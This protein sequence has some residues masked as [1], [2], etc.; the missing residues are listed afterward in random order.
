VQ[1]PSRQLE[2]WMMICQ[3]GTDLHPVTDVQENVDWT[4][5]SRLYTNIAQI[6]S[7]ISSNR[8]LAT[9]QLLNNNADPAQLQASV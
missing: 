8:Q 7:F 2:E 4:S 9:H 6:P 5:S 3:R 1:P